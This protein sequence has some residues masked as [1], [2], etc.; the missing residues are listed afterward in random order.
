MPTQ[1]TTQ[2]KLIALF[3]LS[4]TATA[5][6]DST[7][8]EMEP[9]EGGPE[10]GQGAAGGG[11]QLDT[12]GFM[13]DCEQG[14]A[15]WG[16]P[17]Q[18][19]PC[20]SGISI[21]GVRAEFGPYGVATERNVGQGF[22]NT[23]NFLDTPAACSLFIDAFGADPIGSADLKDI[24]DLDLTLYSV[25][26]PGVMPEGETF[27]LLTWGNGTCAMPE[28]YGP[29]L[30]YVASHGYIIV[31]ANSRYV[32]DGQALRRAI[33]FMFAENDNPDSKY[34][35]KIDTTKVGAMGHSQ[36]SGGA[37][38]ASSDERIST[39]ILFNGRAQAN[40][41]FLAISG[42][43][44]IGDTGSPTVLS[45]PI[46]AAQLPA[47]FI[48]YHHV[49]EVIAE[50]PTGGSAGHL[51]LMMEAERVMD[52]TVAWFDMMLKDDQAAR[53]M[54]LGDDCTLCDGT[55]FESQWD[56]GTPSL[57]YGHNPLLQ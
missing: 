23:L 11:G 34:Y 10:A 35:Q 39:V 53:Q 8:E 46:E 15:N 55:A 13:E 27:P 5:C 12:S 48:Y 50:Q 1:N 30:R 7:T 25:F 4:L 14:G 16:T 18:A 22:E 19:G 17:S 40:K 2:T 49:P 24:H 21:Y 51:T 36:G 45:N 57:T 52:P 6:S 28:G 41:P 47:A 42:E 20:S 9:V 29:L 56:P 31:A 32:G 43:R 3:V 44:D 54:F 26:H 38:A 37:S 33:D